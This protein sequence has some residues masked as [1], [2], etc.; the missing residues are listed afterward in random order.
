[1]SR[2]LTLVMI[3]VVVFAHGSSISAA[4]CRHHSLADHAA[5]RHSSD[6]RVAGI[7]MR[8]EAAA[9]VTSKKGVT[10]DAG[11]VSWPTDMLPAF[12]L[13][14]PFPGT[15][16]LERYPAKAAVLLGSSVRPLLQPPAA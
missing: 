6:A 5:A 10:A 2:L 15:D 16:P 3:F 1:M 13:V 11:S 9:S 8:E 4:I 7:A 12:Q 14:T